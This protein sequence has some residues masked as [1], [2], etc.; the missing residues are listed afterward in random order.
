MINVVWDSMNFVQDKP[1]VSML[2][3]SSKNPSSATWASVKR[4]TVF[5]FSTP[6]FKYSVFKSSRKLDSPYPLLSVISNTYKETITVVEKNKNVLHLNHSLNHWPMSIYMI[7]VTMIIL[8]IIIFIIIT[9]SQPAVKAASLVRDCLPEPSTPT[10]RAWAPSI[11]R[12]RCTLVRC[13]RASSNNTRFILGLFSL[14]SSKISCA[15]KP[16]DIFPCRGEGCVI[17]FGFWLFI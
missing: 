7:T 4:N 10:S 12:I 8:L 3:M 6:S 1:E 16:P 5:L 17:W 14:Y 15:K 9:T 2:L 13:S 11:R